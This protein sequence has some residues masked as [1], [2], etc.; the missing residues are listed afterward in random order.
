MQR[1]QR[2]QKQYMMTE[3]ILKTVCGHIWPFWMLKDKVKT[4]KT[5]YIVK[6]HSCFSFLYGIGLAGSSSP[7]QR[8]ISM[9]TKMMV[10]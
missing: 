4:F 9:V 1:E 2:T 7:R 3:L 6:L 5:L 8:I 10:T